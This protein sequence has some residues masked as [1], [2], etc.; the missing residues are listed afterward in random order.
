MPPQQKIYK[1]YREYSYSESDSES[2]SVKKDPNYE[3]PS[4]IE[5]NDEDDNIKPDYNE[6]AC[7]DDNLPIIKYR[8]R[9]HK[10][11]VKKENNDSNAHLVL[12][13]VV[14][15]INSNSTFHQ[16][17]YSEYIVMFL[18]FGAIFLSF[19]LIYQQ[20]NYDISLFLKN[21]YYYVNKTKL[22]CYPKDAPTQYNVCYVDKNPYTLNYTKLN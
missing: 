1:N 16:Q 9:S 15:K 5:S 10:K 7:L 14:N 20:N 17:M 3:L 12:S 8:L 6:T 11:R 13:N 22:L 4:D 21:L 18:F 19:Y 2:D